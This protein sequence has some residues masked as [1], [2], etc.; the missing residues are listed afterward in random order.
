MLHVFNGLSV[1]HLVVILAA[2]AVSACAIEPQVQAPVETAAIPVEPPPEPLPEIPI[3]PARQPAS[4]LPP[5]VE[6]RPPLA[7][8]VSGRQP[9]YTDVADAL[10]NHYVDSTI[11][12]IAGNEE[13]ADAVLRNVNDV[14]SSAVVAIGLLAARAAIAKTDAPVVYAQ[15]FNHSELDLSR[16]DVRGVA[17]YSPLAEQLAAWRK[18]DPELNRIGVIVGEGHDELIAEARDAARLHGVDLT[19]R[20]THSDQ[21][22][23]YAFRRMSR[24]IDG[25][26]LFPDSRVLSARALRDMAEIAERNRVRFAVPNEGMLSL[27]AAVALTTVASDIAAVIADVLDRIQRGEAADVP[28]LSGLRE[29]DVKTSGTVADAR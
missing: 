23:L 4:L 21:E 26:W 28:R 22:T 9:A 15:V 7:I 1:R 12:Q 13:L 25:F 17:A 29:V 6:Q 20:I 19:V 10:S 18:F 3:E 14:G 27:G 11:Y 2:L 8:V 24:D 16:S 5:P